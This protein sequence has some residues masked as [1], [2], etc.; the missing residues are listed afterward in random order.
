MGISEDE[1]WKVTDR[2]VNKDLFEKDK[3]TGKWKP[4]FEVGVN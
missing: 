4:K 2:I 1:F 3:K